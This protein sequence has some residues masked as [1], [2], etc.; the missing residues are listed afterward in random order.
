MAVGL[1]NAPNEIAA[2]FASSTSDQDVLHESLTELL[3][4]DN[5][6]DPSYDNKLVRCNVWNRLRLAVGPAYRQ[7]DSGFG[8]QPKVQALVVGR[9][10]ARLSSDL[11]GLPAP[12]RNG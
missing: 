4:A 11:L 3:V 6:R 9:V 12:V 10:K 1:Q 7:F 5:S 2:Y 8:A